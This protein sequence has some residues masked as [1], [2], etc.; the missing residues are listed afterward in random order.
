[1]N[2]LKGFVPLNVPAEAV[3]WPPHSASKED[4]ESALSGGLLPPPAPG[5]SELPAALPHPSNAN[6]RATDATEGAALSI[7]M[8][9]LRYPTIPPSSHRVA[10]NAKRNSGPSSGCALQ[11]GWAPRGA[12]CPTAVHLPSRRP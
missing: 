11:R 3:H 4:P 6:V 5:A 12:S 9:E 7:V 2:A 10:N 1:M 8:S